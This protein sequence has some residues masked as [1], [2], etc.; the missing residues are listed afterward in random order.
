MNYG[1]KKDGLVFIPNRHL[2]IKE[3]ESGK[4]YHV[5][6]RETANFFI[7]NKEVS[8]LN[9]YMRGRE[10]IRQLT[11]DS[12]TIPKRRRPTID[13]L[14]KKIEE[15]NLLI[16]LDTENKSY[17]EVKDEIVKDIARLDLTITELQDHIAHL[18]K[19]AEVLLNLN[20][21]DMEN[22]RLARYDYAKMNLTAAIKI[23]EV[24]KEIETS[25]NELSKSI[26]EYEYLVR[27]LELFVSIIDIKSHQSKI[28]FEI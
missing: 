28:N 3:T 5:F 13:T 25:Q 2:D 27:R 14:Q 15:I 10:L 24:E 12:Q 1:V 7:Y 8:E 19:V 18:N 16:E 23:E 4:H 22:R 9:R 6:I 20:N 17:Q 26:D 11:N 21:N